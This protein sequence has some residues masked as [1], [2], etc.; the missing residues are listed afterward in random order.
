MDHSEE[1]GRELVVAGG[2]P[3]EVLH[4]GEEALDQIALAI[5][6]LAEAGFQRRLLFGGMFGVAPALGSAHEWSGSQ[7]LSASTM[8]CGP[9]WASSGWAICH[10][11]FGPSS[12]Q[13][14]SGA[15]V[16]RQRRGSWSS[17]RR[18]SDRDSDLHRRSLL[19]G[20][21]G[22]AVD[23]LD[24]TVIGGGDN[25]RRSQT[26]AFLPSCIGQT[27]RGMLTSNLLSAQLSELFQL[28]DGALIANCAAKARI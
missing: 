22:G 24:V 15:L 14:G 8:V 5:K 13:A 7:A 10:H 26:P 28:V 20:A 11:E 17:A 2:D 19:V 21:K 1:V 9:R 6:L 27:L 12:G 23:H 25:V 3:A 4:L 18:A 16:R